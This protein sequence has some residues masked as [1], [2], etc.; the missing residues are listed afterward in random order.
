MQFLVLY[1]SYAKLQPLSQKYVN[2]MLC[3]KQLK[4]LSRK[5][6]ANTTLVK[7]EAK[8]IKC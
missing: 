4:A 1:L 6:K 3:A 2:E 7:F 8:Y 5:L